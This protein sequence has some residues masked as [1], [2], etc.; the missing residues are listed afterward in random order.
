MTFAEISEIVRSLVKLK[1]P[2]RNLPWSYLLLLRQWLSPLPVIHFEI[3]YTLN[4][5]AIIDHSLMQPLKVSKLPKCPT[6]WEFVRNSLGSI[7]VSR[8][9]KSTM[10]I[11]ALPLLELRV[12]RS[13]RLVWDTLR[14]N[15]PHNAATNKGP[16]TPQAAVVSDSQSNA[17]TVLFA[18]VVRANRL[19]WS[20][21]GPHTSIAHTFTR[22]ASSGQVPRQWSTNPGEMTDRWLLFWFSCALYTN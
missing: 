6:V 8:H 18:L 11:M 22:P 13:W 9:L 20:V 14:N 2:P 17:Q 16:E 7:G 19:R 12:D 3:V 1:S 10:A 21:C 4:C 5:P 15:P